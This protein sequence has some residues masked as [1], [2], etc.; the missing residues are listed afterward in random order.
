MSEDKC[1]KG[2]KAMKRHTVYRCEICGTDYND[3]DQAERCEEY[4][5]TD[6]VIEKVEYKPCDW[7]NHGFPDTVILKSKDGKTAIYRQVA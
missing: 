4:H 5:K 7:V 1:I 6:L 2:E 3:R